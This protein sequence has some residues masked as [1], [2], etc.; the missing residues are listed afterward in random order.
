MKQLIRQYLVV[1]L[2]LSGLAGYGQTIKEE[3]ALASEKNMLPV[4]NENDPNFTPNQV[5]KKWDGFSGVIIAQKTKFVFD[6]ASGADKLNV[7]ETGRRKIK[8]QDKGAVGAYSEFYFRR[9]HPND[10]FSLRIIKADGTVDTVSLLTAVLVEDVGDVPSLFTPYFDKQNTIKDKTKSANIYFKLAVSNLEPGDIIDY[11]YT[12]YNDNDVS[13]MS[14]LEFDPIYYVCHR[15]YPVVSQQFEINTDEKSYVNSKSINGA[16]EFRESKS[17][18]YNVFAW[19]DKDREKIKDTRWVNEY[20]VLPML[21]F[22][23]IY[24]KNNDAEDLFISDRGELKKSITPEELARKVNRIYEKMDASG[25]RKLTQDNIIANYTTSLLSN[26]EYLL[27]KGEAYDLGD[28]EFIK[29]VYYISRHQYGLYGNRLGSQYFAYVLLQKLRKK[30]IP[31]ELIVTTSNSVTEMKDVIFG[32]EL[33]WLVKAKNKF[34][35]S[36]S[37]NSNPFDLKDDFL[38]NDAYVI[39]LGKS[40]TA[41]PIKLPGTTPDDNLN[42]TTIDAAMDERYENMKVTM[43]NTY[44]GIA[45]EDNDGPPLAYTNVYDND[46][47]SYYGDNEIDQLP[48]K[49]REEIE[50]LMR[51]KR[52][53]FKKRKPEYMKRF[54]QNEFSNVVQYDNFLLITDGRTFN[55]QE[56]KYSETFVLGDLTRKAGNNYLISIPALMGGQTQVKPEDRI[57]KYD[58]NVRNPRAYT[59][60]ISFAIPAGYTVKG[61]A[62]L[63]ISVENETGLFTSKA[64]VE[65]TI[66]KLSIKKAYK[67]TQIKKEDFGKMLEFIDAAYDFSQRRILLKKG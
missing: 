41:T 40:P 31:A 14:S 63:N 35:F 39:T 67:Q 27:R 45:K 56:L 53:E 37:A 23:I 42:T 32:T 43:V 26:T 15:E 17:N 55:K 12:V 25:G 22:Q 1:F 47:L 21:K 16:P 54:L 29:R 52:E 6:K 10:G 2:L 51:A 4:W 50:R 38:E 33:E 49:K 58:L 64:V 9:G 62:D 5:P 46:Y 7:F 44:K 60:E 36:F 66:L 8:L 57:R 19:E 28:E 30:N 59:W 11:C 61:L 34:I 65:G 18:G 3:V 20:M 48:E 13:R 24:S